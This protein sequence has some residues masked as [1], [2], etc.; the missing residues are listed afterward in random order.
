[1]DL[2][3]LLKLFLPLVQQLAPL[4]GA[5]LVTFLVQK[6]KQIQGIPVSEGQTARLRTLS[7]GLSIGLM[8]LNAYLNGNLADQSIYD[9]LVKALETF[10]MSHLLYKGHVSQ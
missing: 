1:M 9:P 8:L 2:S 3:N 7:G 5:F 10:L 6:A 4:L